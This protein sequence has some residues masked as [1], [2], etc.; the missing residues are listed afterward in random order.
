MRLDLRSVAAT[1]T[2]SVTRAEIG[3]VLVGISEVMP[4]RRIVVFIVQV[5]A[6]R[7]VL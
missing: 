5:T 2:H 3:H 6:L 4:F 7:A 1:G